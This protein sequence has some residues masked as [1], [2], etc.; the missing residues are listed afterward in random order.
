MRKE[1]NCVGVRDVKPQEFTITVHIRDGVF[2]VKADSRETILTAMERAGLD[3]PSKC[4]AGGC[5][6]CHSRL[7]SGKFTIA[8]ADKRRLADSKFGFIHP[9]CSY[10]DSDM[11]LDVPPAE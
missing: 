3:V 6:Y 9:C 4:R 8:G 2:K 11:E 7:I 5:G 1:S 10:P